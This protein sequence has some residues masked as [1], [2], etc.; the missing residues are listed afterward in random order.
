MQQIERYGVIAL[1]FLLV[2][3]VAVSF[4][5]DSK[6]PG[7]WSRLTGRG[8]KDATTTET[9]NLIPPA[10]SRDRAIDGSLPLSPGASDPYRFGSAAPRA[11]Q[12]TTVDPWTVEPATVQAPPV[13]APA[14]TSYP[15]AVAS[16]P[17]ASSPVPAPA[18]PAAAAAA[19]GPRY[20]VQRGDSLIRI[21]ART[22]GSGSRW[23]EIQALN[24]DIDPRNLR[25][26]TT[27]VLP[28]SARPP[29]G[30]STASQ[31]SARRAKPPAAPAAPAAA[32]S[33]T[34]V[35]RSGDTLSSIAALTLGDGDRWRE[36]L[37][38]NPGLEPKRLFVG[39]AIRLPASVAPALASVVPSPDRPRVR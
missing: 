2:T 5:G 20:V 16:I 27:L 1:V 28:A 21:A 33:G 35:V 18:A 39:K 11:S 17:T 34:Y 32:T 23:T 22:L 12:P 26:G 24:G 14:T 10:A 3:I 9:T 6:S 7:F 38:V 25:I 8:R 36:I 31:P 4:W 30:G 19:A 15:P 29:S 13:Q 37:A